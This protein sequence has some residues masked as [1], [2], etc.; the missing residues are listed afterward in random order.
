MCEK[1]ENPSAQKGAK[2]LPLPKYL[3]CLAECRTS[4]GEARLTYLEPETR[5]C[6]TR[7]LSKQASKQAGTQVRNRFRE[8]P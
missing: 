2:Q 5:L 4:H 7:R 1:K 3:P 6:G 8:L